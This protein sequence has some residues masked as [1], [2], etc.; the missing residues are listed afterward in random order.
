M[1][2]IQ[3]NNGWGYEIYANDSLYIHQENIPSV[4]GSKSFETKED[5]NII[6]NIALD[7]LKQGKIPYI[8]EKELDSCHIKR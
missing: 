2:T 8:S 5:A 7:K 1:K 6:G 3:L 4:E